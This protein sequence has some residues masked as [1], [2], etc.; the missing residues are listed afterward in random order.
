[1]SQSLKLIVLEKKLSVSAEKRKEKK[2]KKT[3]HKSLEFLASE[4]P[5]CQD[6]WS[7]LSRVRM[8]QIEENR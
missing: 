2:R 6:S 7:K 5:W 8:L 4:C 3:E 1:M